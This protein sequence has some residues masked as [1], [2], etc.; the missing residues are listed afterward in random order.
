MKRIVVAAIA[1]FFAIV[2]V[3]SGQ[4]PLPNLGTTDSGTPEPIVIR[5]TVQE[6]AGLIY[7]AE[8]EGFFT[9]NGL[10]VTIH[11]C[12]TGLAC[13]NGMANGESDVAASSEY[14]VVGI[15]LK[16]GNISVSVASINTRASILWE[17][18]ITASIMS[19]TYGVRESA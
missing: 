17:G 3:G 15:V 13:V 18:E 7:I 12:D 5:T 4:W 9:Q 19:L 1:A 11:Y 10:N 2:L 16:Q 8:D 6:L 14:P